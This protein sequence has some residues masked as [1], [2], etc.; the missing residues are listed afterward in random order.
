MYR[1]ALEYNHPIDNA[2]SLFGQ[3]GTSFMP[4]SKPFSLQAN[5]EFRL[6]IRKAFKIGGKAK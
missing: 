5:P 3:A 2:T 6:G 4:N 1:N